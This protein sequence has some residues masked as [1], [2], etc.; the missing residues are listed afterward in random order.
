MRKTRQSD[1]VVLVL[2]LSQRSLIVGAGN[3]P[4]VF[5]IFGQAAVDH[6]VSVI[7]NPSCNTDEPPTIVG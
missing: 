5:V 7:E 2:S 3:E 6:M 1:Y 4:L